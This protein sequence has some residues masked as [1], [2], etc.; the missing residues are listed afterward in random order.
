MA[1]QLI[2]LCCRRNLWEAAQPSYRESAMYRTRAGLSGQ[3]FRVHKETK[4]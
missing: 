4:V 1:Q 2:D 3:G